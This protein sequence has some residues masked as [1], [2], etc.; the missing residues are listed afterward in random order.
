VASNLAFRRNVAVTIIFLC[1]LFVLI[2]VLALPQDC[3]EGSPA[4]EGCGCTEPCD[5]DC[6]DCPC[7]AVC[8]AGGQNCYMLLLTNNV[9]QQTSSATEA[10]SPH[11]YSSARL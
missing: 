2:P 4:P 10:S 9:S 3:G 5:S 8:Q 6:P 7:C 11:P 1:A